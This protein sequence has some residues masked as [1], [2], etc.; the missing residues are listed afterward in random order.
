[1]TIQLDNQT[2]D[3]ILDRIDAILNDLLT[4]RQD[5]Q[6]MVREQASTNIIKELAGSLGPAPSDEFEYFNSLDMSWQRFG[7]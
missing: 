1:M 5:V 4:L 7:Q 2:P 3:V 6:S